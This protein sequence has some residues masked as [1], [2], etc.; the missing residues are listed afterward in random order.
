MLT[1]ITAAV[2]LVIWPV[3]IVPEMTYK[4]SIGTLNLCSL[5][6]CCST[7]TVSVRVTGQCFLLTLRSECLIEYYSIAKLGFYMSDAT[8]DVKP[9]V[10]APEKDVLHFSYFHIVTGVVNILVQTV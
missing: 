7:V 6:C 5:C 1:A 4:V 10:V 9:A 3:K 2:G 8:R